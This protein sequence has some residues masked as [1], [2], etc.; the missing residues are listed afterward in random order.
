MFDWVWYIDYNRRQYLW[1]FPWKVSFV[2]FRLILFW[3]QHSSPLC[4]YFCIFLF[5]EYIFQNANFILPCT[6]IKPPPQKFKKEILWLTFFLFFFYHSTV[7]SYIH[8]SDN[9]GS[10]KRKIKRCWIFVTIMSFVHTVTIYYNKLKSL[11]FFFLGDNFVP[12]LVL[13]DGG[14]YIILVNYLFV[15]ILA[16]VISWIVEGKHTVI[17]DIM[18]FNRII[19]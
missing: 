16:I 6:Q 8:D 15:L 3:T 12:K 9:I 18:S 19:K 11:N 4:W 7:W 13:C 1:R 14:E 10:M 2:G 17:S 5:S